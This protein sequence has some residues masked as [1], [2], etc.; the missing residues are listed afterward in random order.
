MRPFGRGYLPHAQYDPSMGSE[1]PIPGAYAG[2]QGPYFAAQGTPMGPMHGRAGAALPALVPTQ[3]PGQFFVMPSQPPRPPTFAGE[4]SMPQ[5]G[6]NSLTTPTPMQSQG[7]GEV[8]PSGPAPGGP[9]EAA[10]ISIT[11]AHDEKEPLLDPLSG[12]GP[13]TDEVRL[14][15][16][17][18][19]P[20]PN[21]RTQA[22]EERLG[23][24]RS[25]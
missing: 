16:R 24:W 9:R 25:C 19:P 6:L 5:P 10:P 15:P 18:P 4:G 2:H 14:L 3:P 1:R 17:P 23:G 21:E 13:R 22:M 8:R 20:Q 12:S 11:L 7:G